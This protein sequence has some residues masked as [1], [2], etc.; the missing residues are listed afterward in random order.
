MCVCVYVYIY[1][2][3]PAAVHFSLLCSAALCW[4]LCCNILSVCQC[5]YFCISLHLSLLLHFTALV[6]Y[7]LKLQLL[8]PEHKCQSSTKQF[9]RQLLSLTSFADIVCLLFIALLYWI[10]II[11]TT[12]P[13]TCQLHLLCQVSFQQIHWL[14]NQIATLISYKT[15]EEPYLITEPPFLNSVHNLWLTYHFVYI[16][17]C[18]YIH[19]STSTSKLKHH[20]RYSDLL[21]AGQ[22]GDR[23][24]PGTRF[25]TPVQTGP[26]AH[27]ASYTMSAGSFLGVKQRGHGSNHPPPSN[28]GVKERV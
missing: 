19:L 9:V 1:I 23:I 17:H 26:G 8:L 6:I 4:H 2:V 24:L 22:S 28:V 18:L 7:P 27:P 15:S 3:T 11:I 13:C 20:S 25:S 21:Q 16:F 5:H 10:I 14:H 12:L